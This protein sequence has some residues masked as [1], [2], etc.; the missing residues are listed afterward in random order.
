MGV[1]GIVIETITVQGMIIMNITDDMILDAS[2]AM[3]NFMI[4]IIITTII[5]TIITIIIIGRSRYE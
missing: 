4:S 5:T 2:P 3:M 1:S